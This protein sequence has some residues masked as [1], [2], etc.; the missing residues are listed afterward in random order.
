MA[1]I[2]RPEATDGDLSEGKQ[3]TTDELMQA[4]EDD[5]RDLRIPTEPQRPSRYL[6]TVSVLVGVP[7][8][9][10]DSRQRLLNRITLLC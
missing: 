2:L 5:P 4:I 8:T 6:A 1:N 3:L 7:Q 10:T 9:P